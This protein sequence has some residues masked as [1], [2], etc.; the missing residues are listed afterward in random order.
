MEKRTQRATQCALALQDYMVYEEGGVSLS[1]KVGIGV[2]RVSV[3]HIGGVLSRMEYLATGEPLVQA[4]KAEGYAEAGGETL[5]SDKAWRYVSTIFT[6]EHTFPDGYVRL[7]QSQYKSYQMGRQRLPKKA[8]K[9]YLQDTLMDDYTIEKKLKTYVPGA[10]LPTLSPDSPDAETWGS[11]LR[12][13]S[14][15]FVNLGLKEHDFFAAAQYD[16]AMQT[17]HTVLQTVQQ[18]VYSYEGSVNKFLMDDKGS[19]LLAVFGLP[20]LAHENDATRAVLA[21]LSICEKLFD[22]GLLASVGITTGTDIFCGVV[23]SKTRREYTVL[24]DSVNL[25]ARLMQKVGSDGLGGVL[26]DAPTKILAASSGLIFERNDSIRV[27]GKSD[28]IE[29]FQ[30]YDDEVATA[31]CPPGESAANVMRVAHHD[32][33]EAFAKYS[34]LSPHSPHGARRS[35]QGI[36]SGVGPRSAAPNSIPAR[37]MATP[38]TRKKSSFL[39]KGPLNANEPHTSPSHDTAAKS[40][41]SQVALPLR[42]ATLST[43]KLKGPFEQLVQR[44]VK[45]L[46]VLMPEGFRFDKIR[47]DTPHLGP[48]ECA[49][50]KDFKE[51]FAHVLDLAVEKKFMGA[52]EAEQMDEFELN[53]FPTRAFLPKDSTHIKWLP[54]FVRESCSRV[55][56]GDGGADHF[57]LELVLIRQKDKS[58]IVSDAY[59]TSIRLQLLEHKIQ[60]LEKHRGGGI[61]IE[62]EIG[63]GKTTMLSRF[64]TTTLP[65]SATIYCTVGS[66]FDGGKYATTAF[67]VWWIIV[68]QYLTAKA[69][70]AGMGINEAASGDV[71]KYAPQSFPYM[72]F[73]NEPLGLDFAAKSETADKQVLLQRRRDL[74]FALLQGLAEFRTSV[75]VIDDA[76]FL[77]QAS[78]DMALSVV[79][80]A[81]PYLAGA[82]EKPLPILLVLATRPLKNYMHHVDIPKEYNRLCDAASLSFLKLPGLP[83]EQVEELVCDILGQNVTSLSAG[84]QDLI[85]EKS[86]IN[87]LWIQELILSLMQSPELLVYS[88]PTEPSVAEDAPTPERESEADLEPFGDEV[89]CSLMENFDFETDVEEPPSVCKMLGTRVDRLNNCQKLILKT[90]SL[91]DRPS[92]RYSLLHKCYPI[93]GH[94]HRLERECLEL[95]VLGLLRFSRTSNEAADVNGADGAVS[96]RH[97]SMTEY[98]FTFPALRMLVQQL[99]LIEHTERIKPDIEVGLEAQER[100]K[101]KE[102]MEKFEM[103][104][105]PQDSTAAKLTGMLDV[106]RKETGGYKSLKRRVQ[107][108]W[109]KRYVELNWDSFRMYKSNS[110]TDYS[111]AKCTQKIDLRGATAE[112]SKHT[113]EDF[114]RENVFVVHV[115]AGNSF[116]QGQIVDE[117]RTF[118][119]QAESAADASQW[120]F[121]IQYAI[122]RMAMVNSTQKK[123]DGSQPEAS[124][125]VKPKVKF[126]SDAMLFVTIDEAPLANA[127]VAGPANVYCVLEVGDET[128]RTTAVPGI[129]SAPRWREELCLPLKQAMVRD[130][131]VSLSVWDRNSMLSDE[132]LGRT[133]LRLAD[134]EDETFESYMA[135]SK[136]A[137]MKWHTLLPRKPTEPIPLAKISIS[138][139]LVLH[140][141]GASGS[142]AST[143]AMQQGTGEIT[144]ATSPPSENAGEASTIDESNFAADAESWQSRVQST[145]ERIDHVVHRLD[146]GEAWVKTE[147][148]EMRVHLNACLLSGSV[149]RADGADLDDESKLWLA[150]E[151]S[152]QR[153]VSAAGSAPEGLQDATSTQH[154]YYLDHKK[155][156]QGPFTAVMMRAWLK[157][158]YMHHQVMV[159]REGSDKFSPF[160]SHHEL[161]QQDEQKDSATWARMEVAEG[162]PQSQQYKSWEFD[163]HELKSPQQ[164]I[165]LSGSIFADLDFPSGF[166]IPPRIFTAFMSAVHH[167]MS[168]HEQAFFHNFWHSVDVAQVNQPRPHTNPFITLHVLWYCRLFSCFSQFS[169][170]SDY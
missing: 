144:S 124:G 61:I 78:W 146:G 139:R 64:V 122:E 166:N 152:R 119:M 26:C 2:G 120:V 34:L 89:R 140:P 98:E 91:I 128:K 148:E 111:D 138:C 142:S 21:S 62:G 63:S 95:E 28:L 67:G 158:G 121:M 33:R 125:L 168:L 9:N 99:M 54:A 154:Y 110:P 105:S 53:I 107:G 80:G 162:A 48:I 118:Y 76:S 52:T 72:H 109:K 58:A 36:K 167:G 60:L 155:Q 86:G 44:P 81:S 101:R 82:V 70:K 6:A 15:L 108:D 16:D 133:N 66:P 93:E 43:G 131:N 22:L 5:I 79:T 134:I 37:A 73:L 150:T 156:T 59:D 11:E 129:K 103:T 47:R 94:K 38:K 49:N 115:P 127:D 135:D 123:Q 113:N 88:V 23:G 112:M 29:V 151:Y 92:F 104:H 17:V 30:P 132:F 57:V 18:S 157:A 25:S 126:D 163:I 141:K 153:I 12:Q 137:V 74:L 27:K 96:V 32:Q 39:S 169:T 7:G 8:K 161:L 13:L 20:P 4:F 69:K 41:A 35:S 3:L 45:S 85:E 145:V 149:E 14:V 68:L 106:R 1:V 77:D 42:T 159:R 97:S 51:L 71:K 100:A 164:L 84:L 40:S 114:G 90:A 117:R 102:F 147:L 87:P 55:S 130:G 136:P 10:V 83:Q 75:I 31:R 165:A 160:A 116:K 56:Q 46:V 24:G 170:V 65:K 50:F 143:D 19:T